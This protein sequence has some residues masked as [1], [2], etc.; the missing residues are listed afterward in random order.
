MYFSFVTAR[1]LQ[2]EYEAFSI[3]CGALLIEHGALLID[4]GLF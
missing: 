3:E 4:M 2:K 1:A